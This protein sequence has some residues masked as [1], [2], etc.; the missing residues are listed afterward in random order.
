MT[1]YQMVSP[2]GSVTASVRQSGDEVQFHVHVDTSAG[3][4]AVHESLV[5]L[6]HLTASIR[7][8]FG[9]TDR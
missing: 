6:D 5:V 4:T 7:R 3:A 8:Q 2:S 1:D 9:V